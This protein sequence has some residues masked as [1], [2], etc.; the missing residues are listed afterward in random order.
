MSEM[1][2]RLGTIR[3]KAMGVVLVIVGIIWL[4]RH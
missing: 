2:N 3:V 1:Q 4:L